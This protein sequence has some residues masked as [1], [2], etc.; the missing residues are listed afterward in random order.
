MI[1]DYAPWSY[2]VDVWSVGCILYELFTGE[3]LFSARQP[4]L[5]LALIHQLCATMTNP[6]SLE[7]IHSNHPE[8]RPMFYTPGTQMSTRQSHSAM[9]NTAYYKQKYP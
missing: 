1:L 3:M 7:S 2:S 5:H 4:H 9:F 8:L 6:F